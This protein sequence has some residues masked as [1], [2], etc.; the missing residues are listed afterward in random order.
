MGV[1]RAIFK[2]DGTMPEDKDK[3]KIQHSGLEIKYIIFFITRGL[4]PSIPQEEVEFKFF[5]ISYI[6]L[7]FVG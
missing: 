4:I 1:T 3:L 2:L 6:S 5:T 7:S